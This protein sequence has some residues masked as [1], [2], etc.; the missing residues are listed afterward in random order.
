MFTTNNIYVFVVPLYL[1]RQ[2]LNLK[3]ADIAVS[4]RSDVLKQGWGTI[5]MRQNN[6]GT[7]IC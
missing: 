1:T 3:M 5:Y 7:P 6:N 2:I 4:Q